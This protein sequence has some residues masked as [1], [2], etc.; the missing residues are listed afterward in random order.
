MKEKKVITIILLKTIL[1]TICISLY[2]G[3]QNINLAQTDTSKEKFT[4]TDQSKDIARNVNKDITFYVFEY[5]ENSNVINLLKEYN[6]INS[7][8]NYEIINRDDT[9]NKEKYGFED[10]VKAIIAE[11]PDDRREYTTE[12]D[13]YMHDENNNTIDLTEQK[14]TNIINDLSIIEKTKVYFLEGKTN[15]TQYAGL[16]YLESYLKDEYY[17]VGIINLA[18][19]STIPEDCDILALMGLTSDLT[20]KEA[21]NICQYI[22]KG[23][24]IIISLDIDPT[25][26]DRNYPNFQKVLDE[27]A[28][29][30]PNKVVQESSLN[31]V[32][33][34]KNTVIQSS[35]A[36]NHEITRATYNCLT[37]GYSSK[38]ILL[39]SGIIEINTEKMSENNI[40]ATPILMTS[41]SAMLAD[42]VTNNSEE[43]KDDSSYILGTAIQKEIKNGAKSHAVIF[44]S[45]LSFSDSYVDESNT[46]IFFYNGNIIMNSFKFLSHE[47]IKIYNNAKMENHDNHEIENNKRKN[48]STILIFAVGTIIGGIVIASIVVIYFITSKRK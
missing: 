10:G 47:E 5:K 23:G 18:N 31:T 21:N 35:V 33:G 29:S 8:I 48:I 17:E 13:F 42:P 44:A 45:T 16:Y 1:I 15:Y 36:Y 22:E 2:L 14:L 28:V 25:N 37:K 30:M 38:P 24:N 12:F 11:T 7:K 3:M 19:D 43:N 20:E 4:L 46:P 32:T 26:T 39:M 27:Y 6:E 40:T 34:F 9:E 41:N